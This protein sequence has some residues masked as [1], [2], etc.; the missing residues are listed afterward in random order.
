VP[1]LFCF[2]EDES[3]PSSQRTHPLMSSGLLTALTD[4]AS[5]VYRESDADASSHSA[6]PGIDAGESLADGRRRRGFI[7]IVWL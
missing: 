2:I 6:R 7:A 1:S 4:P 5:V 3:A